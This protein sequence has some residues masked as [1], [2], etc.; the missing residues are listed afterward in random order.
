MGKFSTISSS[1]GVCWNFLCSLANS[2]D[3]S[4]AGTFG[5]I[6][7]VGAESENSEVETFWTIGSIDAKS[8]NYE[9]ETS[10]TV[11]DLDVF[12][13]QTFGTLTSCGRTPSPFSQFLGKIPDSLSSIP[14][15]SP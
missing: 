7:S 13:V 8:E 4:K 1:L 2:L 11:G 14:P 3:E 9:A 6:G 10:W 12:E 15:I 5:T